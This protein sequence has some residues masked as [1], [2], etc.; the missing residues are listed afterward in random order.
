MAYHFLT[1]LKT[2]EV[3]TVRSETRDRYLAS[4]GWREFE[5]EEEAKAA[6]PVSFWAFPPNQF[7]VTASEFPISTR[8]QY[9]N[10]L[11]HIFPTKA[12][13]IA[14]YPKPQWARNRFD[15]RKVGPWEA[16]SY[17][18]ASWTL[19]ATEAE[20]R[21]SVPAHFF[22]LHRYL[23]E[24]AKQIT[25]D[26]RDEFE[27]R[28]YIVRATEDECWQDLPRRYTQTPEGRYVLQT[29]PRVQSQGISLYRIDRALVR[30]I[31]EGA[32]EFRLPGVSYD[33]IVTDFLA[34][35][36]RRFTKHHYATRGQIAA[37]STREFSRRMGKI[38]DDT[39]CLCASCQAIP[40]V[41]YAT[42]HDPDGN[43]VCIDCFNRHYG[44]CTQ[45]ENVFRRADMV[46]AEG[47]EL[48]PG[49][50]CREHAPTLTDPAGGKLLA[51]RAN[52]LTRKQSFLM[53][54][55]ETKPDL[56]LGW[57][58]ECYPVG[59]QLARPK[60][61]EAIRAA[62]GE[63]C[64]VKAD[65]TIEQGMEIVS[66]PATLAWHRDYAVQFLRAMKGKLEGWKHDTAGIHVHVG[67]KETTPLTRARLATFST[68]PGSQAFLTHIAGRVP[69]HY[70]QREQQKTLS[71]IGKRN[72]P[73]GRYAALNF[74]T[75]EK[76]TMEWRMFRSNVS[77]LG[78]L[79]NLEFVHAVTF[80]ARDAGNLAVAPSQLG[81]RVAAPGAAGYVSFLE[82]AKKHRGEYPVLWR[83][84]EE[85]GYSET[86]KEAV[87]AFA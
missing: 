80:W 60:A 63:F 17:R 16:V 78:F 3:K 51:Y 2:A 47:D 43:A 28:G 21:A 39:V 31:N 50:Y 56:F 20:A 1:N 42:E 46:Q 86:G 75:G 58:L 76:E 14:A 15:V 65:S 54:S 74:Q 71:A 7:D 67:L 40:L 83:W 57:E 29:L 82:F 27:S 22:A 68:D 64:I 10:A 18:A 12:E 49:W 6:A 5:T 45:C 72:A 73:E 48:A 30:A 38:T 62:F 36:W 53:A 70:S 24:S 81:V 37:D 19:Y 69:N 33:Y 41:S 25:R 8:K 4:D 61:V 34:T 32:R 44:Y 84:L 13:A 77:P 26:K 23:R 66:V 9:E 55:H 87:S 59:G 85:Q 79:K 52:V 35:T 11:W